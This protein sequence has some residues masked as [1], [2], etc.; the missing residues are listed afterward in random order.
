MALKY[1]LIIL[2]AQFGCSKKITELDKL[3]KAN[4][5]GLYGDILSNNQVYKVSEL[6]DYPEINIEKTQELRGSML[7]N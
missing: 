7:K 5:T 4:P 6:L 3:N 1:I 2:L